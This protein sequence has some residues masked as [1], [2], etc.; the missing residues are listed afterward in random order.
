MPKYATEEERQA[1]K[2]ASRAAYEAR[3]HRTTAKYRNRPPREAKPKPAPKPKAARPFVALDG[4]GYDTRAGRH[5]YHLLGAS[6]GTSIEAKRGGLKTRAIFDYLLDLAERNPRAIFV[7]Y[8]LDYD[9]N[10]WLVSVALS[11]CERLRQFG[12]YILRDTQRA[13]YGYRV[14]WLPGKWF[15]VGHG[16]IE[17]TP[18]G[19]MRLGK[20][21]RRI[22]I[23]DVFGFFQQSFVAT[24][25]EWRV[26]SDA[27]RA[28][29]LI[30][31]QQRADF[32]AVNR[33]DIRQYNALE[34]VL[35]ADLMEKLRTALEQ[36]GVKLSLWHGAGAIG[37]ELLRLYRVKEHNA[38][39][40]DVEGLAEAVRCAYFGGRVQLLQPGEHPRSF[41]H[42]L[43]SAY[44]WAMTLLPSLRGEW[45]RRRGWP[46][47]PQWA[48]LWRVSWSLPPDAPVC[49][50]PWRDGD[51][52]VHYPYAGEGWYWAPEVA[53]ALAA[54][55]G[56]I[57]VEWGY[58]LWP[59]EPTSSPFSFVRSLYQRRLDFRDHGD[60]GAQLVIKYGL[61]SLSGKTAQRPGFH[62]AGP[63]AS[64]IWAGLTTAAVRARLL[65]LAT[66]APTQVIAF[67]TDCVFASTP[68]TDHQDGKPL[69]GWEV[70]AA[71]D[72]FIV[73]PGIYSY[74]Q[75]G[76]TTTRVRGFRADE[77]SFDALRDAWR[78]EGVWGY[79]DVN[80]RRFVGLR[81]AVAR[82][83]AALWRRWVTES[84][85]LTLY[86][87]KGFA[88]AKGVGGEDCTGR[89]SA[90]YGAT[91]RD[92]ASDPWAGYAAELMDQ[93]EG[94]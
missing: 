22:R 49:P 46:V 82:G 70:S 50:F 26:G 90:P 18:T 3:T 74:S 40:P 11:D 8:S 81:G 34:C 87:G 43:N 29:L 63:C 72:F 24:L 21:A 62:G 94:L 69:G 91:G 39:I 27:E 45:R 59:D 51:G 30:M 78:S 77:I 67:A 9:V 89:L 52:S 28:R 38:T 19:G 56:C 54:F 2:R 35:L 79:I 83:N 75:H 41:S 64:L 32:A 33:A 60:H 25:Q 23:F 65:R 47:A 57:K 17:R 7:T 4:E 14:E 15:G 93:P 20:G 16:P 85:R 68:L 71:E 76:L 44:P 12:D 66:S 58:E 92:W 88:G 37:S 31:K 73:Q 42:D 1:A 84:R 61:N 10:M 53:A 5:V 55:P 36:V 86:P 80:V 6:D 13:G 48:G